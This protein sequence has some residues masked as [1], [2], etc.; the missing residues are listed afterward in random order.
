[1]GARTFFIGGGKDFLHRS[2]IPTLH[3]KVKFSP[4]CFMS[5]SFGINRWAFFGI[6]GD[7][8]RHKIPRLN[9]TFDDSDTHRQQQQS[10]NAK[11]S[12]GTVVSDSTKKGNPLNDVE[13]A[14]RNIDVKTKYFNDD[15][16]TND[17]TTAKMKTKY[18]KVP[19]QETG[20]FFVYAIQLKIKYF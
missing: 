11:K 1:M 7:L 2:K 14:R 18:D 3:S 6:N 13:G 16:T 5:G 10:S 4:F 20:G 19:H 15:V 12:E 9:D 8:K 17:V